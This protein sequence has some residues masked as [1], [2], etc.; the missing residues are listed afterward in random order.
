MIDLINDD[1]VMLNERSAIKVDDLTCTVDD[2]F[3]YGVIRLFCSKDD[4]DK[5]IIPI[6]LQDSIYS[7]YN[8]NEE[9]GLFF[10]FLTEIQNSKLDYSLLTTENNMPLN[11]INYMTEQTSENFIFYKDPSVIAAPIEDAGPVDIYSESDEF[12]RLK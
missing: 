8:E 3:P 9:A 11:Q 4:D 12:Y 6:T 1:E 10:S 7:I 2:V 5:T